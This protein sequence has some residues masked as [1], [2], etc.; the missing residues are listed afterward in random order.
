MTKM[1][2]KKRGGDG[3]IY[4][5]D[6]RRG[7]FD[8]LILGAYSWRYVVKGASEAFARNEFFLRTL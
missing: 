6:A 7:K 2:E 1:I 4:R 3:N 5:L 8:V